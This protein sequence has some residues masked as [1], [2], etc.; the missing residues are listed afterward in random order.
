MGITKKQLE[1]SMQIAKK[2]IDNLS[3][4][5][6]NDIELTN[7]KD[8]QALV[9]DEVKSKWING[10]VATEGGSNEDGNNII[11]GDIYFSNNSYSEEEQIVGQWVDGKPVYQKVFTLK[12]STASLETGISNVDT[13]VRL[14]GLEKDGL[15]NDYQMP[16]A[17]GSYTRTLYYNKSSDTIKIAGSS[18]TINYSTIVFQYTKTSDESNSFTP[19]M[20]TNN[21]RVAAAPSFED[22][23]EDEICIG[24]WIDGKP[25]YRKIIDIKNVPVKTVVNHNIPNIDTIIKNN[26][27]IKR[28]DDFFI[29]G[30]F[31]NSSDDR[32]I[33][34]VSITSFWWDFKG[35]GSAT[36][37]IAYAILEYTKTTDES[38][39]FDPSM[40]TNSLIIDE[41]TK[42]DVAD[43][44]SVL[45]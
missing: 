24:K 11:Q 42:S 28:V 7:M 16:Y 26:L 36:P 23:S 18:A 19:S 38:N 17:N 30:S 33:S 13:V 27:V 41:V 25:I 35:A 45:E 9:W 37:K 34:V 21:I 6:I 20:L 3:L 4:E 10:T 22:Y 8:K 40:I 29:A 2:Y 14:Y 12:S 43:V 39:S 5:N 44:L 1:D 15:N 31:S 32:G